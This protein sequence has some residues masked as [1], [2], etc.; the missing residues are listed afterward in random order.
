MSEDIRFRPFGIQEK[1]IDDES[2]MIAAF[3]GKRSGK[4]E[5]GAIKS[6][7]WQEQKRNYDPNSIDPFIGAIIAPTTDMLRRLSLKK[8]LSYADPFVKSYNKSTH[9]IVW[10]DG[11]L[12]YGLSADRPQRI[13]GLKLHWGWL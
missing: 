7:I 8:F 1:I 13:E 3:A 11:S 12:I 10:H 2:R 4:T 9:E 6:I 5:I